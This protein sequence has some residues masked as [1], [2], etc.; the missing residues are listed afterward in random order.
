[1]RGGGVDPAAQHMAVGPPPR[2]RRRQIPAR[3][4]QGLSRGLY[5]I[6]MGLRSEGTREWNYSTNLHTAG[7]IQ[8]PQVLLER[9]CADLVLLGASSA[10]PA[11]S[12]DDEQR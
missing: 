5:A 3:Q 11:G 1:M 2:Q 7:G 9:F 4:N 8:P 12:V 6:L 10:P